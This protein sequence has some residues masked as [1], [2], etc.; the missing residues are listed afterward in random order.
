MTQPRIYHICRREEWEA[1]RRAG[2]YA[3]SSQDKSDGFIHFSGAAQVRESARR[4]RA[5]QTGL[6]LLTVDAEALGA[7]LKWEP[8]RGGQLFPHLY[9]TLPVAAVLRIDDLP[10]GADGMHV[11]PPLPAESTG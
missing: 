4:H 1:A 7:A 9:G 10:L 2:A 3:G 11:F 6:V 5:G 8:S